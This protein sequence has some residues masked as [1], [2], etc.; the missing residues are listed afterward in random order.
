MFSNSRWRH[1]PPSSKKQKLLSNVI[2]QSHV[3]MI[4]CFSLPRH[5]PSSAW[6]KHQPGLQPAARWRRGSQS[7]SCF[8]LLLP[9]LY[10]GPVEMQ[11]WYLK[12]KRGNTDACCPS[13]WRGLVRRENRDQASDRETQRRLCYK[14]Y[15]LNCTYPEV[16]IHVAWENGPIIIRSLQIGWLVICLLS[17]LFLKSF[18][19]ADHYL[20]AFALQQTN[21]C[22]DNE[23]SSASERNKNQDLTHLKQFLQQSRK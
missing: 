4:W 22:L 10:E 8:L 1:I 16:I 3:M 15:L 12:N 14:L 18:L 23:Q 17:K 9:A 21:E 13:R 7:L 19:V 20:L 2:T 5:V 6:E 11:W